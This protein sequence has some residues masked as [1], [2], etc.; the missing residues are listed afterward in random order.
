VARGISIFTDGACSGNPGPGGWA[1]ILTDYKKVRELCG[2]E[3]PTTNNRME[4][5]GLIEGLRA[6]K[7]R[8]GQVNVYSDSVYVLRGASQWLYGWKK[9]G[10]KTSDGSPV[11]N[12]DLWEKLDGILKTWNGKIEWNHLKGH[13]GIPANERCDVLA[14]AASQGEEVDLYSG[15]IKNYPVDLTDLPE[16]TSL[17][18]QKAPGTKALP[19]AYL[20]NIGG[21][22]VR[23]SNWGSCEARVKGRS[24][25][26]FKKVMSPDEEANLLESW[27]V[28]LEQV[29][30]G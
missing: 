17:P 7:D 6:V 11:V 15:D 16:D 1:C 18:T 26:K 10:W 14:V 9:K 22:V 29:K 3:A 30:D 27:G 5:M 4:L 8:E 24:G 28:K 2:R 19:Y 20:S 25:A 21:L 23:H 13:S 12:R